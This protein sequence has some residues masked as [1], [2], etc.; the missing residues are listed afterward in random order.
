MRANE[1]RPTQA[2][3]DL[4]AIQTN[5]KTIQEHYSEDIITYVAVK[6]NAYGHGAVEVAK[7]ALDVGVEGLFV[8]TVDEGIELRQAGITNVPILVT[9]LTDPRGIAEVFDYD[10]TLTVS[11]IAFFEKAVDQLTT[12][13]QRHLLDKELP[14]HLAL[15]TGMGRI[16][17]QK[18]EEILAF[19]K[20]LEAYPWVRWEGVFTHFSTA[21][22]G[23]KDYID[24]QWE[25]WQDLLKVVPEEVTYRHHANT[26]MA[27]LTDDYPTDIARIGIGMY[28]I[29][30]EDRSPDPYGL[31]PALSLVSAIIY[32][33]EVDPGRFISYGATYK[34]QEKEWIATIPLGYA[35]GWF[36][37]YQNFDVLVQGKKCPV[38]GRINMDQL[39][40]RLPKEF[41]VGTTVTFIGQ[42]SGQSNHVS[43]LARVADT[44]GYEVV[45]GIS[46]RVPRVHVNVRQ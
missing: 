27:Y 15:D 10:L 35:D 29:D 12:T 3:I 28:G 38:V 2:I 5:L 14:I 45:C 41:P 19:I 31:V 44:I 25:R 46:D 39:M 36:R 11:G 26:A 16:G 23:P 13:Q 33:K 22:G 40:V 4:G 32:V 8:A 9:G 24:T 21:S 34:T 17:L 42:N 30:A 1:H 43:D 20:G 7:A 6:A 37:R 18:P